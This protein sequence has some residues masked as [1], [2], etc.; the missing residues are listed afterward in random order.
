MTAVTDRAFQRRVKEGGAEV[1]HLDIDELTGTTAFGLFSGR[2]AIAADRVLHGEQPD[3]R[4]RKALTRA[5]TLL[6]ALT[7]DRLAT[8]RP[9]AVSFLVTEGL[10]ALE[11]YR[12][13]DDGLFEELKRFREAV[14]TI[15]DGRGADVE[16][17][18]LTQLRDLFQAMSEW[19]LT[20]AND[21]G[22]PSA[23]GRSWVLSNANSRS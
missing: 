19:A 6:G 5:H 7:D 10:E 21:L 3:D 14:Q 8:Q 20:H 4:E 12:P 22:E 9:R 18:Q 15:L 23:P 11:S 17:A 2:T 1:T 16:Q 13:L